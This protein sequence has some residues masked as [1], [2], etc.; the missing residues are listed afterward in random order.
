MRLTNTLTKKKE[1]L[2]P[3]GQTITL[4]TCGPTV[5]QEP[6][7]GNWRTFIFYDLLV[8]TLKLYGY[9]VKNVLN[10]TDVGHLVSNADEGE[11]K[12]HLQA[13]QEHNTAQK[14]AQHYT[15]LFEKGLEQ[16]GIVK[17]WQMPRATDHI[18]EQI[19]MIKVLEEKGFIYQ[20]DDGVYFDTS[21]FPAYGQ[22]AGFDPDAT[23]A[24]AR[25]APNPQKRYP[26]DFALWKFSPS[27][28][29]RD[30]EWESPWGL[31][32]PGWHL[33]C[34]AMALKYLGKT[35]D[36]HA[37]GSD[38]IGVHHPNEIAQSEAANDA[39]LA[40]LWLHTEFL[41]V[42]G[43]KMSKSLG[44]TYLLSDLAAKADIAAFRLLV[45]MSHYRS[46]QNFTWEA[47][48][49]AGSFLRRLQGWA[50]LRFQAQAN[51]KSQSELIVGAQ[52]VFLSSLADD[53]NSP[54]AIAA[55]TGLIDVTVT[56]GLSQSDTAAFNDLLEIVDEGLGLNLLGSADVTA[57]QRG[58]IQQRAEARQA[59]DFD[60][61]D[62]LRK[63]LRGQGI[64]V[65]DTGYGQRWSRI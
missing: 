16:L 38:H 4:Y 43:R 48:A 54:Q 57:E 41:L 34:S 30:M 45:L 19:E 65:E 61:S 46:Q 26:A 6:H 53:L 31:G 12:L 62:Q 13:K 49:D 22:L 44:N 36:I 42:D 15:R 47:L 52:Q 55:L 1:N 32:F 28:E 7:I 50:D 27:G 40:K 17:P 29:Q 8:R 2:P 23:K 33:E 20:I 37:G 10:I 51:A 24:Q 63:Q 18:P 58:L 5:Y 3:P 11:D 60:Q 21:K 9:E 64:A 35:L 14:L 59:K 56:N 39:P 25:I